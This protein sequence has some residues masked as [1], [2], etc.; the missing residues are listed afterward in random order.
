MHMYMNN[1]SGADLLNNQSKFK[2]LNIFYAV[3]FIIIFNDFSMH[4]NSNPISQNSLELTLHLLA[5]SADNLCK[6]FGPRSGPK[7]FSGLICFQY[8]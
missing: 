7:I 3:F 6:Q 5:S 1:T 2:K 4:V 8:V